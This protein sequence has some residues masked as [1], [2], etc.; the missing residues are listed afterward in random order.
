MAREN[1]GLQFALIAFVILTLL[2]GVSTF[3]FYQQSQDAAMRAQASEQDAKEKAR[4]NTTIQEEN[5]RLK[6]L[7]GF[8]ATMG[9]DEVSAKFAEDMRNYGT[10][11]PEENRFYSPVL[12]YLFQTIQERDSEVVEL[13]NELQSLKDEYQVAEAG[14]K[15]QIDEFQNTM[16]DARQRVVQ[17]TAS[18]KR[19]RDRLTG[20]QQ[21]LHAKLAKAHEQQRASAAEVERKMRDMGGR[22]KTLITQ[23]QRQGEMIKNVTRESF[24]VPDGEIRWVNQHNGT[25]WIDLGRADALTRQVTFSV[26]PADVTDMTRSGKKGSIEVTQL[27]GDHLAEARILEDA[28]SDPIMPGDKIFTPVW[29]PGQQKH[30]A[31]AGIL[32]VDGDGKSDLHVVRNL[33]TMNGGVI[34]SYMDEKGDRHG[35]MSMNT[36]FLV[37][38]KAPDSNEQ[39][40]VL[41]T[42]TQMMKDADRFGL[43]EVPVGDLLQRMGEPMRREVIGFGRG[44]N[45]DDFRAKPAEGRQKA[46]T[47][48][49]SELFKQRNPR[50]SQR[51]GAY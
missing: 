37:L 33:I 25:V 40:K 11:F 29:S 42:Y 6:E 46:S 30:F 22:I 5:N 32:D 47:G 51:S 39:P 41:A 36:R 21:Q 2:L 7:M 48:N 50:S 18:Q 3:M 34:D 49:V 28:A 26:Y 13:K 16:A 44:A 4:A 23:N 35:T 27:L 14:R 31:L 10:N 17:A 45:P 20:E 24:E 8:P 9:L 38:G 43:Q 15:G 19:D 12:A 1:Q